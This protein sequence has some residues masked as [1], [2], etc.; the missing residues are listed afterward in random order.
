MIQIRKKS[1]YIIFLISFLLCLFSE[2]A[3]AIAPDAGVTSNL[4]DVKCSDTE[5][6]ISISFNQAM[7][8]MES[9]LNIT[10]YVDDFKDEFL[11]FVKT[12]W[13]ADAKSAVVT[14]SVNAD[15]KLEKKDIDLFI[16][17][18]ET[19]DGQAFRKTYFGLFSAES[20]PP[21]ISNELYV[22]PACHNEETG[23]ISLTATGGTGSYTYEWSK[24][25][26]TP[27]IG[28]SSGN[29]LGAGLYSIKVIG[30]DQCFAQSEGELIN[31]EELTLNTKI[32]QNVVRKD[33]GIIQLVATGGAPDYTYK[34]DGVTYTDGRA[35][36]LSIGTYNVEVTDDVNCNVSDIAEILDHRTPTAFIPNNSGQNDIFM[37][38]K[39]V[40]IFDRN[41]TLLHK[42]NNGWDGKYKG[43]IMRPAVYFYI[44]TFPDGSEKKGTVQIFKK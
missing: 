11:Q 3:S 18:V 44:V 31:P 17:N 41:G 39:S 28:S 35:E 36:N 14:Y 33:D 2:S 38:G 27:I 15:K 37:E 16:S 21:E 7:K 24:D 9:Y 43:T 23:S 32:I 10:G 13:A 42:G 1:I 8:P 4:P 12:E 34:I 22:S 20:N 25:G 5:V 19:A 26:E 40:K 30:A 29:N 6:I